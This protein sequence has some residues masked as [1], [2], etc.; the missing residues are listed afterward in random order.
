M[1]NTW[2]LTDQKEIKPKMCSLLQLAN[3]GA[4]WAVQKWTIF[5][6]VSLVCAHCNKTTETVVHALADC[7]LVSVF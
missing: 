2:K 7:R 4:H 6:N 3:T 1:H 5:I